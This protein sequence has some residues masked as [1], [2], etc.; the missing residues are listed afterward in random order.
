MKVLYY[1]PPFWIK[2]WRVRDTEAFPE[3]HTWAV[4]KPRSG[5]LF[6]LCFLEKNLWSSPD[7]KVLFLIS[8][9]CRRT[10][11]KFK[12]TT[13][14][15]HNF[16]YDPSQLSISNWFFSCCLNQM[17]KKL[18]LEDLMTP[19]LYLITW[20]HWGLCLCNSQDRRANTNLAGHA[21]CICCPRIWA[22][23]ETVT[24]SPGLAFTLTRLLC[25]NLLSSDR[26]GFN[27]WVSHVQL[28]T[29]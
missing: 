26:E 29:L 20:F 7:R 8:S 2:E 12:V 3:S 23:T 11:V 22:E 13:K 21:L 5:R 27:S 16:S 18:S 19:N 17:F 25:L 14:T 15:H 28:L 9:M 6:Q 1:I 24:S 10:G 4:T